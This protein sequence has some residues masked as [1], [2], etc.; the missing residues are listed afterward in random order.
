MQCF[1]YF[2]G[3]GSFKVDKK[4]NYTP[5]YPT[6]CLKL[7]DNL[8]F[9]L[10]YLS[11]IIR[12]FVFFSDTLSEIIRLFVLYMFRVRLFLLLLRP[13]TNSA[14]IFSKAN[15]YSNYEY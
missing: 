1:D 10:D 2:A 5:V 11:K 14:S 6:I 12:Y 4:D 9:L 15:L 8:S 3:S 7:S 13:M